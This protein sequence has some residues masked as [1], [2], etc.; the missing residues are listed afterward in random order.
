VGVRFTGSAEEL[1]PGRE[2]GFL[3]LY[4][5]PAESRQ[6]EVVPDHRV[7]DVLGDDDSQA[8]L[9]V[10]HLLF[11]YRSLHHPRSVDD[12]LPGNADTVG[13]NRSD[14]DRHPDLDPGGIIVGPVVLVE[15]RGQFLVQMPD[16][17]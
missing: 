15:R 8:G 14:I 6:A 5:D 10:L 17:Q 4:L 3:D 11:E 2:T 16:D 13:G 1:H 12:G 7:V 9:A